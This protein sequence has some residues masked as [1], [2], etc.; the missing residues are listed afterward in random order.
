MKK[1]VFIVHT[2]FNKRDYQRF[3][4]EILRNR[5]YE[6]QVWD[7]IPLINPNYFKNYTPP[8]PVEFDK[9]FLVYKEKDIEILISQLSSNDIAVC[10]VQIEKKAVFIYDQLER[11]KV[12]YGFL[13]LGLLPKKEKCLRDKIT[14]ALRNPKLVIKKIINILGKN[15]INIKPADFLIVGGESA[16]NDRRY[17]ISKN[18]KIIKAH[19]YDYDRY[20][21]LEHEEAHQKRNEKYAVFLDEFTPFHP[22]VLFLGSKQEC[23]TEKYYPPL[24]KFFQYLEDELNLKVIIAAHPRAN[25][26]KLS[27]PFGTRVIEYGK[28]AKLVKHSL[29]VLSHA[30]TSINFAVIYK[31]PIIFL[32]HSAY[33]KS[34]RENIHSLA[35]VFK[36][37]AFDLSK[38]FPPVE[39]LKKELEINHAVYNE[40]KTKFIKERNTPEKSIWD[41]FADYLDCL[42][43]N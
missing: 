13:L 39:E 41:I 6:V 42:K 23:S 31:K 20:L 17:P 14:L 2:T 37:K 30:S 11:N 40:Y 32:V 4:I 22:D 36:K 15:S 10:M 19:A 8:D 28:T 26:D 7:A 18:T 12:R 27:N 43:F 25:Y 3:G 38:P 33:I 21:E 16:L 29:I 5:G 34:F 9:Y 35:S 24:R 1:V